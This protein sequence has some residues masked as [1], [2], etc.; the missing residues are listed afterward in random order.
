M[1]AVRAVL[2][3]IIVAGV[4]VLE[5]LVQRPVSQG[6]PWLV[7]VVAVAGLGLAAVAPLLGALQ[8]LAAVMVLQITSTAMALLVR[9][10][11]VAAVVVAVTFS[12]VG[13]E[14]AG[15]VALA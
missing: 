14:M 13:K 3:V 5:V 8:L 9:S 2:A 6:Q 15:T 11:Q 10:I 7:A 4:G 12:L 1:A